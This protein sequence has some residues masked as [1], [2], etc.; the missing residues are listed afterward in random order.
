MEKFD[1]VIIGSGLGG[2]LCANILSKEGYKVC[3]LEKHFQIG[4]C[5]Q[6]FT[7]EGCTFDT[8]I[9][10]IGRL[11]EGEVLHQYFKYFGLTEKVKLKKLDEDGFDVIGFGDS[12]EEFK[13]AMG[14]ARFAEKLSENFPEEREALKKYSETLNEISDCFPLYNLNEIKTNIDETEFFT[15]SAFDFIASFT[16]NKRLQNVLAGTN[17]LYAGVKEKTPLFIH[18]LINNSYI[19]SAWKVV[20]GSSQ[21]ADVLAENIINDGGTII[22]SAEA[23]KMIFEG[24]ELKS[25]ELAN[26]ERIEAKYFISN[27]HPSE[28][29]KMIDPDQ[30][31]SVYRSRLLAIENTISTF[32]LYIV[33]KKESFGYLNYNYY[34]Y[35]TNEVWATGNYSKENWPKSYMMITSADPKNNEFAESITVLA[36]MTYE[37]VKKW[38]NTKVE[39]RGEDYEEFK[40][41]RAEKLIDVIEKKFPDIRKH[42][43]SYYTSSPLTYKDYTS[44]KEGSI[45][46]ILR[47]CN[48]PMRSSI[49][50]RTKIPNLF[51]TGQNIILHGVL[52]VTIGAVVTC[53]EIVGMNNLISKIKNA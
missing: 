41:E 45:Y 22:K 48:E 30:T 51:F 21:I 5:L 14:S 38:E 46:G 13:Y 28:T 20:G 2:L 37:E 53:S 52:G 12:D 43:K 50:P 42:I 18:A 19:E 7:R 32:N 9:H 27:I 11:G 24:H 49:S 10:Y 4:G 36:Y 40:K 26:G 47:D 6:N 29:L 35:D 44:T 3:V 16:E 39:K 23:K 15:K 8:G 25:V 17:L 1:A 31:R 34:Y 33:L